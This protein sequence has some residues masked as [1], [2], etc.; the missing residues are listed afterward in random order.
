VRLPVFALCF[1]AALAAGFFTET[2]LYIAAGLLAA[3]LAA[4]IENLAE[5][6][7]VKVRYEKLFLNKGESPVLIFD[8]RKRLRGEVVCQNWV[9]GDISRTDTDIHKDRTLTLS[10]QDKCGALLIRYFKFYRY[11]LLGLTKRLAVCCADECVT[12]LPAGP[13]AELEDII[14]ETTGGEE[15][16]GVREARPDDSL[17]RVNLKLTH[18]FG[19]PYINTYSPDRKGELWLAVDCGHGDRADIIAEKICGIAQLMTAK[20]MS[21]GLALPD[22]EGGVKLMDNTDGD[23]VQSEIL[24]MQLYS[25]NVHSIMDKLTDELDEDAEILAFT[26]NDNVNDERITIIN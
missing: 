3:L 22:N 14:T 2:G 11:D 12:V 23:S 24:C 6:C 10:V 16:D 1:A 5:D 9:T 25:T 21:Y 8:G 13:S 7:R 26:A 17:R 4:A 15:L 18:R 19:K 20:G